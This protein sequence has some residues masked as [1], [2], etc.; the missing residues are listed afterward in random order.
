MSDFKP[1][2]TYKK[3]SS[4]ASDAPRE[5]LIKEKKRSLASR[6]TKVDDDEEE[7]DSEYIEDATPGPG[8]Y[9]NPQTASTFK[10]QHKEHQFQI[11]GSASTR[12]SDPVQPVTKSIGPGHYHKNDTLVKR[13]FNKK[14]AT[15]AF[16]VQEPR[17]TKGIIQVN[18]NPGPGHY[19]N[20]QTVV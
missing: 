9:Y 15:V 7:D 14:A 19:E 11:F 16:D 4:F 17:F 8:Y 1:L 2:Y 10:T 3:T 5:G 12:F 13:T 20:E 6:R 18:P